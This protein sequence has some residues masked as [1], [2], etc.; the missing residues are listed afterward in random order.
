MHSAPR[1]GAPSRRTAA[2][3]AAATLVA[4]AACGTGDSVPR[5]TAWR[6]V[7]DTIGD[8]VIVRTTGVTD[9]EA[10][11]R[12][13]PELTIGELEG[14]DEYMF[15]S[16]AAI[17]PAPGGGV[18]VWDQ[19]IV[20]LRQ[21]DSTGRFVRRLGGK[22]GGP[23]E[24]EA[25]NDVV[26]LPD[27][28]I[29][30]WDPRNARINIYSPDGS[31]L[32]AWRPPSGLFAGQPSMWVD[33]SGNVALIAWLHPAGTARAGGGPPEQPTTVLPR[34]GP[35]GSVRDTLVPPLPD[36][37]A[38]TLVA[39]HEGRT[40]WQ[41]VPFAPAP[42]WTLLPTGEFVTG[43]GDSY[44]LTVHRT[45]APLLRI[46]RE[47]QQPSVEDEEAADARDVLTARMR[48][49]DPNWR[50]NGPAV[51]P[52]KPFFNRLFTDPEGRIWVERPARGER[53]GDEE[54]AELVAGQ[55]S[56]FGPPIQPSRW[57]QL[58]AY[59]VFAADGRFLGHVPVPPRTT[60]R[61]MRGDRVWAVTRDSMD[62]N[63]VTR[64]RL[65]PAP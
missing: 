16:V 46:E 44:V 10:T 37:A 54:Y 50:W 41:Y 22:G 1:P 26:V 48:S 60:L 59:D 39:S 20:A 32:G 58:I 33:S 57:R 27:G 61:L 19:T 18:Y 9:S 23:G 4:S 51:P 40:S 28:R 8:T 49:V 35:D 7:T 15:G 55:S 30:L 36:A 56:S 5:A 52:V 3:L 13:V 29:L 14:P 62:V 47:A 25:G 11:L 21:Y 31:P 12:L 42:A 64:F 2:L 63:F 17:A 45:G 34:L 38:P 6:T 53:L 43:R 24:Y 65:E